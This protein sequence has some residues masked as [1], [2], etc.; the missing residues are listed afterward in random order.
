VARNPYFH[1]WSHAA[2]PIGYPDRIVWQQTDTDEAGLTAVER[3]TADYLFDGV[4]QDRLSE[5]LTRF[6]SQLHVTPTN[7]TLALI[8]N[9]RT[10]P[11]TDVRVRRAINYAID[12][13]KIAHLVGQDTQPA[14]QILPAGFPATGATAPTPSTPTPPGHGGRRTSRRQNA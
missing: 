8:L 12:R 10:A 6:A 1:E 13:A 5:A 11:F 14:C 3:G 9:T 7:S 2:R 4:P